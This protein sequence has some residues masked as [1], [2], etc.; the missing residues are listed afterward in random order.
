M[1][2]NDRAFMIMVINILSK[3][4]HVLSSVYFITIESFHVLSIKQKQIVYA[5][6]QLVFIIKESLRAWGV[7]N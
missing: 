3:L 7:R 4:Q 2:N 1:E 5:K 6:P